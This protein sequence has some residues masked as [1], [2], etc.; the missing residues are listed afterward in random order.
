MQNSLILVAYNY[1]DRIMH[2][3]NITLSQ[4]SWV[5]MTTW[6]TPHSTE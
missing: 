6:V 3:C 2:L 4:R 5:A 1:Y